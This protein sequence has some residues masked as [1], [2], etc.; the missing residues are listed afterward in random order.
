MSRLRRA[1]S[2]DKPAT[3]CPF[4]LRNN[5]RQEILARGRESLAAISWLQCEAATLRRPQST[6]CIG[7]GAHI[8][9]RNEQSCLPRMPRSDPLG[10]AGCFRP[11]PIEP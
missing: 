1:G 5:E 10:V 6:R 7:R 3:D 8:R 11:E 4:G 9:S 2:G